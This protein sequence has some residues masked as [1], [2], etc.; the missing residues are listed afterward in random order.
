MRVSSAV[1]GWPVKGGDDAKKAQ[2]L[3]GV[4]QVSL[5]MGQPE[6]GLEMWRAG[7]DGAELRGSEEMYAFPCQGARVIAAIDHGVTLWTIHHAIMEIESWW[8]TR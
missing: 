6:R 2:M 3:G 1:T 5:E 7:F 4:A 8:D